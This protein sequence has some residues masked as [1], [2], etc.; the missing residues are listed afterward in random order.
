M[1]YVIDYKEEL[2]K[3]ISES[4]ESAD[5]LSKEFKMTTEMIVIFVK[6]VF[7]DN[8]VDDHLVYQALSELGFKPE[9]EK[10]LQYFWYFK[11]K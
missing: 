6:K 5:T 3:L 7:P 1:A 10:P 9:E 8:A 2:K 4:Y 11:R